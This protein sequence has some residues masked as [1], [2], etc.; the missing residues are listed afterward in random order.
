MRFFEKFRSIKSWLQQIKACVHKQGYVST[1][2]GRRRYLNDI[3]SQVFA[4][5]SQAE[6]QAV[7]TVIQGTASEVI[8]S[9][10]LLVEEEISRSQELQ[11]SMKDSHDGKL[12]EVS[13]KRNMTETE[14][15]FH[16]SRLILQI[17][18]ELVYE[19]DITRGQHS[20]LHFVNLLKTCMEQQVVHA[21]ELKIPLMVKV[22]TGEKW[23]EMQPFE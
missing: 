13:V 7:N 12:G 3:T 17:H 21:L 11:H 1:L 4:R 22:Q 14:I 23:G 6:R 18:D 5:R 9:A 2:L 15:P 8:K 10:M 20:L 16:A 19:V